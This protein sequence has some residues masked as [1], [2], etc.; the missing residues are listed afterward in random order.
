[1]PGSPRYTMDSPHTLDISVVPCSA[2]CEPGDPA[3]DTSGGAVAGGKLVSKCTSEPLVRQL[4]CMLSLAPSLMLTWTPL[5]VQRVRVICVPAPCTDTYARAASWPSSASISHCDTS[6]VPP[7]CALS[8]LMLQLTNRPEAPPMTLA[9]HCMMHLSA[10]TDAPWPSA[11]ML[12]LLAPVSVQRC[13][14]ALPPGPLTNTRMVLPVS[15]LQSI[16]TEPLV[17]TSMRMPSRSSG[18]VSVQSFNFSTAWLQDSTPTATI[19]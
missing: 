5:E 1:M 11:M 10:L 18:A 17:A 6:S 3:A 12:L 13:R 7:S 14:V 15:V 2:T 4:S 8:S 19:G 9:L 16:L